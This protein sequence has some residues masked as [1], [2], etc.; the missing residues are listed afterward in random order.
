[1]IYFVDEDVSQVRPFVTELLLRGYEVV[2]IVDADEAYRRLIK[3]DSCEAVIIDVMLAV[4]TAAE[5]SRYTRENTADFTLTG[6]RLLEHL[7]AQ[8]GTVFPHRAILFTM[9]SGTE[10]LTEIQRV[11]KKFSVPFLHKAQFSTPHSF[12]ERIVQIID[13]KARSIA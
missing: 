11:S 8:N 3:I 4:D 9:A 1:M 6:V 2:S 12:G 13:S 7:A 5:S 10:V